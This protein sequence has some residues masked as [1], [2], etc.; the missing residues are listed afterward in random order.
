MARAFNVVFASW[1]IRKRINAAT[2]EIEAER[3]GQIN[4]Q[5]PGPMVKENGFKN[6]RNTQ[7]A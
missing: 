7:F 5:G 4:G 3:M 1:W 2:K 6:Q